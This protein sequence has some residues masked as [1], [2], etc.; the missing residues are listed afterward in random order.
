[1]SRIAEAAESSYVSRF[2]PHLA[3]CVK[4]I[5]DQIDQDDDDNDDA[6]R[7]ELRN[8]VSKWTQLSTFSH[9]VLSTLS[10][11]ISPSNPSGK[12]HNESDVMTDELPSQSSIAEMDTSTSQSSSSNDSI[13][14]QQCS[15]VSMSDTSQSQ[16]Q[17][18]SMDTDVSQSI[19]TPASPSVP[20]A[21]SSHNTESSRRVSPSLPRAPSVDSSELN[22]RPR[23]DV[24]DSLPMSP[25]TDVDRTG[26]SNEQQTENLPSSEKD[27]AD[28]MD[29]SDDSDAD[30]AVAS[31]CASPSITGDADESELTRTPERVFKPD[32][33]TDTSAFEASETVSPSR[34]PGLETALASASPSLETASA[35]ASPGLETALASASPG[36]ETASTSSSSK[37]RKSPDS[38]VAEQG[39]AEN[40]DGG[41]NDETENRTDNVSASVETSATSSSSPQ[42]VLSSSARA[43][44]DGK[45]LQQQQGV[46]V[47][48]VVVKKEQG[49]SVA[50]DSEQKNDVPNPEASSKSPELK[51]ESLSS[52]I[53]DML[54]NTAKRQKREVINL[55]EGISFWVCDAF[56]ALCGQSLRP[57]TTRAEQ[58]QV[59][60]RCESM[61]YRYARWS[62]RIFG[63]HVSALIVTSRGALEG[64]NAFLVTAQTN[65]F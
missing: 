40:N 22:I 20:S 30:A 9:D 3:K 17:T 48:V 2:E 31:P 25:T 24:L 55:D 26:N 36:L 58:F 14:S 64:H 32:A 11:L 12:S 16:S 4:A 59:S 61:K 63:A 52:Q 54:P 34:S 62:E 5:V 44:K 28:A 43:K 65:R 15:S 60:L 46:D 1:M 13:K 53:L 33:Y 8:I 38:P 19:S 27:D 35:P 39:A 21:K 42:A 7:A 29:E 50:G 45:H 10:A 41:D 56:C 51:T 18:V 37:K 57:R 6:S 47:K 49:V 23:P